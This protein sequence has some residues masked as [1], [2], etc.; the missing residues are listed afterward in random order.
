MELPYTV[1]RFLAHSA[2][3]VY[4]VFQYPVYCTY[5]RMQTTLFQDR[6]R[7]ELM[8]L[9]KQETISVETT[10]VLSQE[11]LLLSQQFPEEIPESEI[12]LWFARFPDISFDH[13]QFTALQH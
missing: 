10:T 2:E 9:L 8:R 6:M 5:I 4:G 7:D 1:R 11:A 12:D 13:R 3:D